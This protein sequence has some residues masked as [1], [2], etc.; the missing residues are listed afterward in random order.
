MET[1][2]LTSPSASETSSRM[3]LETR[4]SEGPYGRP[5]FAGHQRQRSS[6]AVQPQPTIKEE[7]SIANLRHAPAS[8]DYEEVTTVRGYL[9]WERE[10]DEECRR[11]RDV[12]ED[13]EESKQALSGESSCFHCLRLVCSSVSLPAAKDSG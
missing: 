3:S 10:A 4:L 13:S 1:P 9:A 7:P 11:V 12:W 8:S 2:G 5:F 6:A